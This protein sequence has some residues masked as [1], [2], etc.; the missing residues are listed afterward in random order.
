VVD[1]CNQQ[2]L[3][4][5]L[6]VLQQLPHL[7][8]HHLAELE[9]IDERLTKILLQADRDCTPPTTSPWSPELNQAYLRHRMWTIALTA[10]WT[11]R[12]LSAAINLIRQRLTPSPL[13]A[14][15]PTRSLSIN[16]RNSQKAL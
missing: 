1:R 3:A 2:R 4:E 14:L 9:A 16:L 15:E 8:P 10:H 7:D 12:D 11:K 6:A 5:R 13:D